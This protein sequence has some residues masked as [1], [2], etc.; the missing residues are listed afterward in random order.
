MSQMER[1]DHHWAAAAVDAKRV[2]DHA[3]PS[4]DPSKL[5]T[6]DLKTLR[7]LQAILDTTSVSKAAKLVGISQ[8]GASRALEKLRTALDDPILVRNRQGYALSARAES[9]RPIIGDTMGAIERVFAPETFEPAGTNRTFR[10]AATDYGSAAILP[11]LISRVLQAAPKARIEVVPFAAATFEELGSGSLDFALYGDGDLG[12]D[13][14]YRVV[15][16]DSYVAVV[17]RGHP[18]LRDGDDD[19]AIFSA[20]AAW[21]RVVMMQPD[22][23]RLLPND[24]L[25][26]AGLANAQNT[27]HMPYVLAAP[28]LV[29]NTDLVFCIPGRIAALL[30]ERQDLAVINP[31]E[32]IAPFEYRVVWHGRSHR[33]PAL[34]WI[35]SLARNLR[36]TVC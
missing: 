24:V 34:R 35:R 6:L 26:R 21:P 36:A 29:S 11:G 20:L 25:A 13:F 31:T 32:R 7:V 33:D 2:A 23:F 27:V 8:P 12:P 1:A 14:H 5:D 17:R 15:A 30:A 3:V 16:Q 18:A 19:P 4:M 10:I 9:L 28:A 22:G